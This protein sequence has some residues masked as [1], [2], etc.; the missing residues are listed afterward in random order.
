MK[1]MEWLET[2]KQ[3]ENAK[4]FK[5]GNTVKADK[6]TRKEGQNHERQTIN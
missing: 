4:K 1:W 2:M 5:A 6:Q 3:R